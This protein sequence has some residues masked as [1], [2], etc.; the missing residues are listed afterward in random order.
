MIGLFAAE[1]Y[2]SLSKYLNSYW[3]ATEGA[4]VANVPQVAVQSF[5]SILPKELKSPTDT[6]ELEDQMITLI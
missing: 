2:P 1:V 4:Q 6:A 3:P 5:L